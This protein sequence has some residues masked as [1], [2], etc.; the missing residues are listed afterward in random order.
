MSIKNK[1]LQAGDFVEI[2]LE[3]LLINSCDDRVKQDYVKYELVLTNNK[4]RLSKIVQ[5]KQE[6]VRFSSSQTENLKGN[7]QIFI[8][9]YINEQDKFSLNFGN[10]YFRQSLFTSSNSKTE[11]MIEVIEEILKGRIKQE[12][13]SYTINNRSITKFSPREL[14]EILKFYKKQ[15]YDEKINEMTA[16][17][18]ARAQ[19]RLIHEVQ[20]DF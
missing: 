18:K 12:Y 4:E 2:S 8:L 1:Q 7:Y 11:E 17:Q 19:L 13:V 14:V 6:I 9:F 10:V 5:N 16:E 20:H 15:L 3:D